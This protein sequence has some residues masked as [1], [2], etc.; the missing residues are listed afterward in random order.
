VIF[1]IKTKVIKIPV[2]EKEKYIILGIAD[3]TKKNY[4]YL[5]RN[6]FF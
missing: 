2:I 1:F 5:L 3:D 6:S 4:F